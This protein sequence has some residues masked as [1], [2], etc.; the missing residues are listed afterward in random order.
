MGGPAIAEGAVFY[1]ITISFDSFMVAVEVWPKVKGPLRFID[2]AL[3]RR[4][5]GQLASSSPTSKIDRVPP[6][7][8]IRIRKTLVKEE[9]QLAWRKL[10]AENSCSDH[11]GSVRAGKVT[12]KEWKV[13]NTQCDECSQMVHHW[14]GNGSSWKEKNAEDL[15]KS[16]GLELAYDYSI[17]TSFDEGREQDW[18][19]S[20][21]MI[22]LRNT[23]TNAST[24]AFDEY[25]DGIST[26]HDFDV[27]LPNNPIARFQHFVETMQVR[28][29]RIQAGVNTERVVPVPTEVIKPRWR[30]WVVCNENR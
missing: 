12:W 9:T 23:A 11:A 13:L 10:V 16:F 7:V 14:A 3:L 25:E 5:R 29:M 17:Q 18:K 4:S 2:L 28:V 24:Y 1:G 26:L 22:G 15:L 30:L 6:E 21:I 27:S 20:L 19:N 8:W